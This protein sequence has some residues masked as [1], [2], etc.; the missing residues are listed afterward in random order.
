MLVCYGKKIAVRSDAQAE[1]SRNGT[2]VQAASYLVPTDPRGLVASL[3]D[4]CFEPWLRRRNNPS[5]SDRE[6]LPANASL[7]DFVSEIG[8]HVVFFVV[9]MQVVFCIGSAQQ[10]EIA[11]EFRI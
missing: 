4:Q 11:E 7:P 3:V 8:L 10:H 5:R 1:P 9:W 6:L 2:Y